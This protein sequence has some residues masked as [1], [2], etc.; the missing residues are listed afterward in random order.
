MFTQTMVAHQEAISASRPTVRRVADARVAV[1]QTKLSARKAG[2]SVTRDDV[3]SL[4]TIVPVGI[5][6]FM[7]FGLLLSPF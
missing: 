2:F 5:L 7:T 4:V 6:A 1:P 3:S